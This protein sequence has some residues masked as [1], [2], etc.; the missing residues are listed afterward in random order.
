MTADEERAAE[1]ARELDRLNLDRRLTEQR[2][3]FEAEAACRGPAERGRD[4]GRGRGVAPGGGR[5]RGVAAGRAPPAPLR[6]DRPGRRRGARVGAQHPRRTTYMRASRAGA[7]HLVRFGGHRMAAGLEIEAGEVGRVPAGVRA[8]RGRAPRTGRTCCRVQRVDAV[9]SPA[10]LTLDLA[11]ELE[12]LGPFGAGNPAPTLLVPGGADR[13]RHRD[14]RGRRPRALQPRRRVGA[15]PRRRVPHLPAWPRGQPGREPHDAAVSLERRRWN[16][17]RRG[18]RRP[19]LAVRH[20]RRQAARR[21][22]RPRSSGARS[23]AS[24]AADPSAVVAGVPGRRARGRSET[25]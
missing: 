5:H 4:R 7:E 19:A 3:L 8:P 16:G 22:A 23:S 13:A 1:V 10:A 18:A 6:G 24:C 20:A 25:G 15:R 11:E 14:G 21:R 12:R 2:I 9:V 17:D